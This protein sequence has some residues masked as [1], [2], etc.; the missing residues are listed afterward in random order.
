MFLHHKPSPDVIRKFIASQ[1]ELPFSYRQVGATQTAAPSDYI[2]DHNRTKLGA[3]ED[4]YRRSVFALQSWK[5]FDLGWVTVV[6]TET[7][8]RI[9]NVVAVQATVL[10]LWSLNACRIV[11][12]INEDPDLKEKF[13]FAY[14]TLPDHAERGEERF[15][16]EW[17]NDDSVWYDIYAFSRPQS[18]LARLAFPYVRKLQK[19]F[20]QDSMAVMRAVS[21]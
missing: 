21:Q 11:Y 5:Q 4:T 13:G 8:L 17:H 6:P 15:T 19:R 2:I 1:R 20:A 7:A 9:G 3:G 12:L 10:G 18:M 16:I 14:G